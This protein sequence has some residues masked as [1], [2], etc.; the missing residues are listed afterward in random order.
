MA[1]PRLRPGLVLV[2]FAG[3][4]ALLAVALGGAD[5][6]AT[7]APAAPVADLDDYGPTSK[8]PGGGELGATLPGTNR[9][10]Y[11]AVLGDL[12]PN[13]EVTAAVIDAP[14]T[15]SGTA[16]LTGTTAGNRSGRAVI[17]KIDNVAPARPQVGLLQADI[18]YEE[19]VEA[20]F[21][22]LAAV[23]H[24]RQLDSV[25]PVRSGRSTDIGIVGSYSDPVFAFS[26]ANS[27]FDGL[28]D[29][30]PLV[31]RG[32]EVWSGYWRVAGR[33]APHNLFTST[34]RLR[35]STSEGSAPKAQFAYRSSGEALASSAVPA[36]LIQLR[37]RESGSVAITYEWS[38]KSGGWLRSQGGT[39]HVDA[40]GKQVA[41][42][43]VVVQVVDYV[44]TGLTDKWGEILYEG[45]NVGSG[46]A[47]VFTNG[48]VVAGTWTRP[49]LRSVTTFTDVDGNH[50]ELTPGTTWVSLVPPGGVSFDSPRCEGKPATIIGTNGR[51]NLRGTSG[52]DVI[53]G[54]GGADVI[55]AG[56]GNDLVCAGSGDD[57][58]FGG[59]WNDR[60]IGGSGDDDLR[61]G[62]GK[63]RLYGGD[64]ADQLHGERGVDYL[65]GN[66]GAD[67]LFGTPGEDTFNSG[68]SDVIVRGP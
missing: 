2:M 25:G 29:D 15:R 61:G 55:D 33:R 56:G 60:L 3:I 34:N 36:D 48:H 22:R 67:Q 19:L 21:T 4:A 9:W 40:A 37:Y 10:R 54:L 50:I 1:L 43:N 62:S 23:F 12:S 51:D 49:T 27:I 26:G 57:L 11:R 17:V 16:P 6:E 28:I 13:E 65:R 58:V 32:A 46:D 35:D 52:A 20:G 66:A 68:A 24:S 39:K 7:Y 30:A 63:D 14:S 45:V 38:E 59:T 18:V 41:P 8:A 53:M 47:L 44:D 42:A 64:G 5:S 31:N